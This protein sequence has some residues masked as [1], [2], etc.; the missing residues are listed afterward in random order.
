VEQLADVDQL[1]AG[2]R[3]VVAV[4]MFDGVHRGHLEM[5]R[6]AVAAGRRLGAK[7][8]V[9]TFHPHP[10]TVLRGATPPLLCDAAEKMALLERAG[11]DYVV[12]QPFDRRFAEQPAE[13]FLR[14]LAQGRALVGVVMS[15]ETAF[16]R[17]R[18]G[19]LAAVEQM[20]PTLGF[21]VIRVA[22]VA[23]GGRRVSSGRIR[24]AI[25]SGRLAVARRLLGRNYAVVGEVVH[26]DGRG[27]DLGFPTANLRF[28]G[29]VVLPPNGIY[30]VRVAWDG[31][32]AD[33]V[34]SLGVRPTFGAGERLLEVH[35]FDFDGDL[36]G[37]RLRV[38]FVRR[39]RGERK[40]GSVEALVK[41]MERDAQRARTLLGAVAAE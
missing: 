30:A 25:A 3:F 11:A 18:D 34:A 36:Y 21:E 40:F 16:G 13:S 41:Q 24:E 23:R 32:T 5:L 17:D 29:P 39:Q 4:G 28:D 9:V 20:A 38:E 26:G 15:P 7:P 31:R 33:G 19:T 10:E 8:V 1:P 2:L 37:R 35:L 12:L 6:T 22:Q 27:R 14:R